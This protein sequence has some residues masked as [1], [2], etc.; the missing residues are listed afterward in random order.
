MV[1]DAHEHTGID[2]QKIRGRNILNAPQPKPT[3]ASVLTLSSGGTA[4][5][6]ND[7]N[8]IILNLKTRINDIETVLRN[9]GLII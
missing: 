7:D 3:T 5:L 4:V 1:S 9:L 2:A 8:T 6:T